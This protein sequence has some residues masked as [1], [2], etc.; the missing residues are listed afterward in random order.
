[1]QP[2]SCA[3]VTAVTNLCIFQLGFL[4]AYFVA[5]ATW[6]GSREGGGAFP[7]MRLALGSRKQPFPCIDS[8]VAGWTPLR[9]RLLFQSEQ[10]GATLERRSH[11]ED[12][13]SALKDGRG[14]GR[15]LGPHQMFLRR[16]DKVDRQVH[17]W[18]GCG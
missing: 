16:D 5:I 8:R 2:G 1:M 14:V 17:E 6:A 18:T 7:S 11:V 9:S 10:D 3:S 12:P 15:E 4:H 13:G